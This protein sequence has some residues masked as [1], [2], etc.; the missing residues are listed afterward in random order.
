MSRALAAAALLLALPAA[1]ED[2]PAAPSRPRIV[3]ERLSLKGVEKALGE[4]IEGQLCQALGAAAQAE[5]ICPDDIAAAATLARQS[6]LFG[7]CTT[8]DC[9]RRVD[10][11]R[12]AERRVSGSLTI[13]DDGIVL[14][15]TLSERNGQPISRTLQKL[16]KDLDGCVA[17]APEVLK[18]LFK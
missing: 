9:M 4:T 8:D 17:A 14:S 3:L 12:D 10:A 7:E 16:P 18:K 15:L 1:A 13:A 2:A 5:A 6:A 11:I